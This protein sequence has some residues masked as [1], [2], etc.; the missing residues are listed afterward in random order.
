M[1]RATLRVGYGQPQAN[2]AGPRGSRAEPVERWLGLGPAV[3]RQ[4]S[5]WRALFLSQGQNLH[6]NFRKLTD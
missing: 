1:S 6:G 4:S 2:G 5:D 3:A